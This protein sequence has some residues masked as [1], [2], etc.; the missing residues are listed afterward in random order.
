MYKNAKIEQNENIVQ[1]KKPELNFRYCIC[2]IP[3][4]N[5]RGQML[6]KHLPTEKR[7]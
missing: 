1:G 4:Y 5:N 7:D 2:I 3:N 6:H